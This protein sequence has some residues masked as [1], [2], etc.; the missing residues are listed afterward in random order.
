MP[1][2]GGACRGDHVDGVG[3]RGLGGERGGES[4]A[5]RFAERLDD[6]TAGLAGVGAQ[7]RGAACVRDDG[8]AVA[9]REWL[10]TQHRSHVE[11]LAD[12]VGTDH[13]RVPEERV[14]GG[15]SGREQ[16]SGVRGGGALAG[17]RAPAL[18]G[19]DRFLGGNAARY[20]TELGRVT[21]RLEVEGNY[22]RAL[23]RLPV[24][25]EI[26]T[27]Q[28]RLVA[29][30]Y[31]RGQA[32]PVTPGKVEGGDAECATLGGEAHPAG[33]R[34]AG[35]EARVQRDGRVGV[36]HAEAVGTHEAHAGGPAHGDAARADA[37]SPASPTSENPADRTTRAPTPA[38]AQSR[39]T[40]TTWAAGTPM[41]ASSRL[42]DIAQRG[43]G[44]QAFNRRGVGIDGVDLPREA[45][46]DQVRHDRRPDAAGS[47]RRAHHGDRPGAQ[48]VRH[49]GHGGRALALLEQATAGRGQ[50]GREGDLELARLRANFNRESGLAKR[51]DH[52][53]VAGQHRGGELAHI[54]GG[55][56]L[57][58]LGE[59]EGGYATALPVICHG[60][61]D[62]RAA[63][64]VREVLAVSHHVPVIRGNGEKARAPTRFG[65]QARHLA[66]VRRAGE[67]TERARLVGELA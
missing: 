55:R 8:H 64:S 54:L 62:L 21:E 49:S 61:R 20:A 27:G 60:E 31:E 52:P 44:R 30:R 16:R 22:V 67:K 56:S 17:S 9:R 58:E 34:R 63:G 48:H 46:G 12:R 24:L 25:K 11:H 33:R 41:T 18:D 40:S 13:A 42:G 29:G 15:I 23:V 39:A 28:V 47:P 37:R 50:A 38:A 5:G 45:A 19:D 10:A 4:C 66:E 26:V 59:Q 43:V 2:V 32:D 53:A 14:D 51:P 35:R 6:E 1:V 36:D 65:E 3:Y 57:G 7:D